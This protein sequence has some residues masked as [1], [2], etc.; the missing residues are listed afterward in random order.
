MG[1][2]KKHTPKQ[3]VNVLRQ[4]ASAITFRGM[5]GGVVWEWPGA[6]AWGAVFS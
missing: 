4:I 6:I 1:K 2:A 5:G 3:I